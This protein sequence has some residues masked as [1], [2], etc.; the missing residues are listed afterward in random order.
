MAAASDTSRG[1]EAPAGG[2]QRVALAEIEAAGA[3]VAAVDVPSRTTDPGAVALPC[4]PG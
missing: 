3:D 4:S 2:E 1:P